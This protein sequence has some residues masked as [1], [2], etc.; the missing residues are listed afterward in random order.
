MR[1]LVVLVFIVSC[2]LSCDD[3]KTNR[4]TRYVPKSAFLEAFPKRAKLN[5]AKKW[6]KELT[7]LDGS[8]TLRYS[9][10]YDRKTKMNNIHLDGTSDTLKCWAS[11]YNKSYFLSEPKDSTYNIYMVN[12]GDTA[13]AGLIG[14]TT[15]QMKQVDESVEND[16]L[17]DLLIEKSNDGKRY[18]LEADKKKIFKHYTIF[19]AATK[20]FKRLPTN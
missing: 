1:S 3:S 8:D 7:L 13:V 19:L 9:I 15:H 11:R 20:T 5:L 10:S 16:L 12:V 2:M 4:P 14:C 6:G 17:G 18:L